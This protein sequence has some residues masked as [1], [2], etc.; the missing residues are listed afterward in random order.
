M[1][2]CPI[3]AEIR[4][5]AGELAAAPDV[6]GDLAGDAALLYRRERMMALGM[7][8]V[9][10]MVQDGPQEISENDERL[11]AVRKRFR[12]R[13]QALLSWARTTG[14]MATSF[15]GQQT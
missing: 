11:R 7:A 14:R 4:A 10:A 8:A 12:D 5:L 3:E 6:V 13:L 15:R 9:D 1:T 2:E